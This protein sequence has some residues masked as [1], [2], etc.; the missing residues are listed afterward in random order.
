MSGQALH[1]REPSINIAYIRSAYIFK[2][3]LIRNAL[4]CT[5][6]IFIKVRKWCII[7]RPE[8][9]RFPIVIAIV[10][11]GASHAHEPEKYL[12]FR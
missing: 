1:V 9:K 5:N 12:N 7:L 8:M 4:I 6:L 10:G 11:T 2:Y 3:A